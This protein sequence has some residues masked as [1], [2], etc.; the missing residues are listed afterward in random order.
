MRLALGLVALPGPL[1]VALSILLTVLFVALPIFAL[2]RA[3]AEEWT[4]AKGFTLLGAGAALHAGCALAVARVLPETGVATV[5]TQ[6]LGQ[7]GLAMWTLG[8]GALL[9]QLIRDKNL[10]IPVAIFLAGFDVFLIFNPT[11]ITQQLVQQQPEF[12]TSVAMSVPQ[13][14]AVTEGGPPP[15]RVEP[16]AYVG[17]AD[18]FFTATF[19]VLLFRHRMR[20]EQTVRWLVPVLAVY[21]ALVLLPT[22]FR[23]LPA[24]VPIG[25]VV[26]LVNLREFKMTREEKVATVGVALLSVALATY[27]VYRGVTAPKAPPTGPS[28]SGGGQAPPERATTPVP[29][30]RG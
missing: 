26:L 22:G 11:S 23:M 12:F 7:V 3:A 6:S 20:V 19:F 16:L 13:A 9:A 29:A 2:F 18:L 27:G 1:A 4:P 30:P 10:I 21:L 28:T 5:V 17:P 14:R 15:A 24:L 8:L 25:A